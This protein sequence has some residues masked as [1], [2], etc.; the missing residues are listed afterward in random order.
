MP[1]G[2]DVTKPLPVRV[3]SRACVTPAVNVANTMRAVSIVTVH[4]P[5]P[6][7]APDQPSNVEAASAVALSITVLPA[8][9]VASHSAPQSIPAGLDRTTPPP[10]PNGTTVS[11][12]VL[13]VNVAVTTWSALIVTAQM[14]V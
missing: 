14:P 10:L 1:D 9:N 8:P 5:V 4:A 3:T 6:L 11:R 13:P 2:L 12:G 7:H